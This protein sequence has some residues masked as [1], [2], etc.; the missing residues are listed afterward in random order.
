MLK[1]QDYL[2]DGAAIY[3]R[4]FAIIRAEADLARFSAE[5]ADIVVRMIHACGQVEA[6]RAH[7]VR[8]RPGCR[9]TR[10]AG[11]RRADPVRCR[12]GGAWRHPRAAAGQATRWSARCAIRACRRLPRS[13]APRAPPP[14]S[15]SGAT[16]WRARW[17]PSA[18]R[19]PRCFACSRCSRR[20]RRGRRR[21]SASRSASSAP[22]NPR[23][24]SPPI[25]RGVPY[26]IVR[27]R[28]GG[29]AMTAAAVNALARAGTMSAPR[30]IGVGVGPGDP[31]LLTLKAVAR[32]AGGRRRRAFRQGGQREQRARHRRLPSQARRRGAA[33]ALSRDH[34]D[35]AGRTRPIASAHRATSTTARREAIAAHLDAG[36]TVA[37]DL[38]GRSAVLRLLHASACAARAA[39][40][41]RD[42]GRRDRHVGLLVG[43]RRRR[44]RRATT[45]SPCF[46]ARCRRTSWSAGSPTPTPPW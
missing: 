39:L 18:T 41:D 33:A 40:S 44:S 9:G 14:R 2:R 8:R 13:S 28:M 17:S 12:D 22:P 26:L 5:E 6:A 37:R 27:G 25:R 24:R 31:E 23:R 10:G 42:R 35:P 45:C 43:G 20:A 38:R 1:A 36:R 32:A 3:E 21:F 7:R 15:S 30:C 16:G 19:R 46:P 4:S 29:S 34:R 11:A